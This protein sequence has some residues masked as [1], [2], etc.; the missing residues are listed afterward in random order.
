MNKNEPKTYTKHIGDTIQDELTNEYNNIKIKL[1]QIYYS[2][3]ENGYMITN[4]K[5]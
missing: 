4:E 1:I 3:I 2:G 5:I